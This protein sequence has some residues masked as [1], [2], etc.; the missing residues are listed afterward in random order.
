MEREGARLWKD[1][2][3]RPLR[4][5]LQEGLDSHEPFL[6]S[7]WLFVSGPPGSG[8]HPEEG[9]VQM[10]TSVI[11]GNTV[12][13]LIQERGDA[14]PSPKTWGLVLGTCSAPRRLQVRKGTCVQKCGSMHRVHGHGLGCVTGL[15]RQSCVGVRAGL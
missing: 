12:G 15:I 1:L 7:P 10:G 6:V 5:G 3:A 4:S 13:V 9:C 14:D 8:G 2:G 11:P